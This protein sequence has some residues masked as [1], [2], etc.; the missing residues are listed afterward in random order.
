MDLDEALDWVAAHTHAVL[1]TLRRDGRAQSSD[2][3]Y[4]VEGPGSGDGDDRHLL[5]SITD[6]RA[7]TA[8]M[9]RD[10]RVV[11]HVTSPSTWS[12]VSMDGTVELM[13]VASSPD[14]D[15]VEALVRYY[16]A[17][18]GG[19][20]PDWDEYRRAMVDDRRL[21]ARFHPASAVGQ[22]NR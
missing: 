12:Y 2:V 6:D 5:I 21:I 4:A 17:V 15:T 10:N 16:E 22:I 13:P 3:S 11:V 1:I 7:K 20:H 19:P 8:N 18:T 14:D 9:R